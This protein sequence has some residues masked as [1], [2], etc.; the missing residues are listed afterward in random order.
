MFTRLSELIVLCFQCIPHTQRGKWM[1]MVQ[2]EPQMHRTTEDKAMLWR[3]QCWPK[4][5]QS[6]GQTASQKTRAPITADIFSRKKSG[7]VL[8]VVSRPVAGTNNRSKNCGEKSSYRK[9]G[10]WD[11]HTAV[12]GW[13]FWLVGGAREKK[14]A[15]EPTGEVGQDVTSGCTTGFQSTACGL[16]AGKISWRRRL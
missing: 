13:V 1:D 6:S 11:Y 5:A 10:L 15:A 2:N 8:F 12:G 7:P 4:V 16:L 9:P 3:S 14:N